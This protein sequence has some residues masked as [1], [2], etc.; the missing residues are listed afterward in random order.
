MCPA[1]DWI[2]RKCGIGFLRL[3]FRLL[4]WGLGFR[5]LGWGLG[6]RLLEWGL[7]T[8]NSCVYC[9]EGTRWQLYFQHEQ[10]VFND[11][12]RISCI[13]LTTSNMYVCLYTNVHSSHTA[14]EGYSSEDARRLIEVKPVG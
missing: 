3:G 11:H 5:L 8:T 2:E 13:P 10:T 12:S 14:R 9:R 4:E 6:F 7:G 1:I